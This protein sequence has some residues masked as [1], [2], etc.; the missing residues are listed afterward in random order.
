MNSSDLIR[1]IA[2]KTGGTLRETKEVLDTFIDIVKTEVDEDKTITLYSFGKFYLATRKATTGKNPK[3]GK[4]CNVQSM[5]CVRFKP[6]RNMR[7]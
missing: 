6:S 3:T 5:S 7:K 2:A 1:K 4:L